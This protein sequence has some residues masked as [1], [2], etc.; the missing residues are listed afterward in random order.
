MSIFDIFK[1]AKSS[2]DNE[3]KSYVP[4]LSGTKI[5]GQSYPIVSRKFDGEK[6]PGELGVIQNSIP[7]YQAIRLRAY[8]ADL[9]T[10]IIKIITDRFY[11]WVIGNGLKLQA[12]PNEEVLKLDGIKEDFEVFKTV[13]ESRFQQWAKSK[14]A[15]YSKMDNLHVKIKEAY[16]TAYLGGD[17]LFVI[18]VENGFPNV[19][20]ID[21]IHVCTPIGDN[22]VLKL[23]EDGNT[24]THGVERN[25]KGEHV[26]YYVKLATFKYERISVYGKGSNRKLAWLIYGDK[27][28]VDHVRGVSCI[29]SILEKVAKLD[30][31]VEASVSK[32]EQAANI[33]MAIQHDNTSTGENPFDSLK[34]KQSDNK[35]VGALPDNYQLADKMAN[36]ITETTSNQ[37]F[38]LPIGSKLVS[39]GTNIETTF[40]TFFRAM[41][42][43]L[44]ASVGVPPEVAMQMYNSNYSAS[45]AAINNWGYIV[46]LGREKLSN[47]TYLPVYS[48]FLETEVLRGKI[49]MPSYLIALQK[50]DFMQIES[51]TNCR[52]IGKN[53]PHIDPLKEVKAIRAMLG[54]DNTPLISHEQ[55]TE[56]LNQGDWN[57]NYKK[58]L[59]ED[60]IIVKPLNDTNNGTI[61]S[62]NP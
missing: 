53:M 17:C 38:N 2:S 12:E 27:K 48:L 52:F 3:V 34:L 58:F 51:F 25:S 10:D 1:K 7:D 29:A 44:C 24:I 57:A 43:S 21:G 50:N 45:R 49:N 20:V 54:D 36:A 61:S 22:E 14:N 4:D 47:E 15:D 60:E 13:V 40:D 5:Y 6:T 62:Q 30:R 42:N 55:A 8:D 56:T 46:D 39:F 18:R 32:A 23:K 31:Y 19:Q 28:R 11:D 26:A 37:T 16:K 9:R 41:I 33:V 35:A 59:K